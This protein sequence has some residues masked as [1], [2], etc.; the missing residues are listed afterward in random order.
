MVW[1]EV[2]TVSEVQRAGREFAATAY[3]ADRPPVQPEKAGGDPL[4]GRH[5]DHFEIRGLLGEGGMGRVYL[6][7]DLSLDRPVALKLLRGELASNPELVARMVDEARAQARLQHPNVVTIYYIGQY[8]GASYF[9]ME[10][11]RGKTLGEWLE[12]HGPLPWGDALEYVIQTARALAVAHSRG[13]IHRDVKPSNLLLGDVVAPLHRSEI[14]VADFGLATSG[15]QAP[16]HF[17]GT[18]YYAAPEQLAGGAPDF[19]GDV[20]A[21]AVTFY[22]LL[23]GQVPFR[24]DSLGAIAELHRTAP[25]P[26]I[27]NQV[28][29]WRLRQLILEMMDP[30]PQRR[31]ESY[32]ALLSRLESLRPKPRVAGG[33][34]PRGV[35]LAIDL[36]LL[37]PIGQIVAAA[38]SWSQQAATQ[39]WLLVFGSYY[40]IAHR[41]WGKTVG[42]RLLGLHV[43]GTTR[44]V[45]V[46][47]LLLRFAVEFWGPLAALAM[48]SL[49]IGVVTDLVEVKNRLIGAMGAGPMPIWDSGVDVVLRTMLVPN[50]I[51]AVPWLA[52]FL[53]AL[54]DR[55]RQTLHDRAARTRV[56]YEVR[57]LEQER[58]AA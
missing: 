27:A 33:L 42:K 53:F 37:A 17:A 52:G 9:V 7:H 48:I 4:I 15:G 19:R 12:K 38:L 25:R 18:P 58:R 43:V 34:V 32:D 2:K 8:E 57:V 49:Q 35:A 11:V 46:P 40:V 56:I 54:V 21:L 39:I 55:D 50:L 45:R 44:R 3:D 23:T 29:P 16:G 31:P 22:E 5:I 41:L 26:Q 1:T 36:M 24:A 14:K 20:Y 28:A 47:G 10:Y 30:D 13:M 6:A 51:V